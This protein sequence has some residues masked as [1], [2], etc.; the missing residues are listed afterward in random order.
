MCRTRELS[1]SSFA[2]DVS[3]TELFKSFQGKVSGP[4][5]EESPEACRQSDIDFIRSSSQVV[6]WMRS[7][8]TA[9]VV[10]LHFWVSKCGR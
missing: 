10:V 3:L 7:A 5:P 4:L 2:A 9:S 8:F 6:D 1:V